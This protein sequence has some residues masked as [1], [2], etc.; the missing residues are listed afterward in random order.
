[1]HDLERPHLGSV[2]LHG[3]KEV[4]GRLL[5]LDDLDQRAVDQW[6]LLSRS[7]GA[8]MEHVRGDVVQQVS[9]ASQGQAGRH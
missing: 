5:H 2:Q 4:R 3:R 7:G 9:G 1:V 8:G 6:D